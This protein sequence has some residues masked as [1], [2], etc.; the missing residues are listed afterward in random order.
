MNIEMSNKQHLIEDSIYS[1]KRED[2]KGEIFP[3]MPED[4]IRFNW[5]ESPKSISTNA[6]LTNNAGN[7]SLIHENGEYNI[8]I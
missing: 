6:S 5:T 2:Y 7:E 4:K 1:C 8:T 3:T